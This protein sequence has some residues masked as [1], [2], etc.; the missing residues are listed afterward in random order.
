METPLFGLHLMVSSPLGLS[1]EIALASEREKGEME[2]MTRL[3]SKS[4][5]R[6]HHC[7]ASL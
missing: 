1:Q 5:S 7:A 2:V 4:A 6:A 3:P